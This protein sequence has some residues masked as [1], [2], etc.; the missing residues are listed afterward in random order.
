M[1]VLKAISLIVIAVLGITA[2]ADNSMK[3]KGMGEVGEFSK[4]DTEWQA[5]LTPQEYHVLRE[6]GTEPAF[7]GKYW[8]TKTRGTYQCAACGQELFT[9]DAKYDSGTGWPSFCQSAA[10]ENLKLEQD[11][12]LGMARTEVLCSRCGSHLGHVFDDGPPPTGKRFC[13][14]SISLKL[15][16]E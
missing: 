7:T 5:I 14:N 13:I 12:S 4:T 6:K 10:P 8:N 2:C 3:K 1:S 11:I 16:E 9:S 15:E